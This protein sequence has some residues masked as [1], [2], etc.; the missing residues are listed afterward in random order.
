M[1]EVIG[2]EPTRLRSKNPPLYLIS[3]TSMMKKLTEGSFAHSQVHINFGNQRFL[4]A[5]VD[6][7]NGRVDRTRTCIKPGI[8]NRWA[9]NCPTTRWKGTSEINW[10]SHKLESIKRNRFKLNDCSPAV[11]CGLRS[12][13]RSDRNR[14]RIRWFGITC[15]TVTLLTYINGALIRPRTE[16]PGVQNQN[17]TRLNYEGL[18]D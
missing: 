15:V 6:L 7:S 11:T 17:F 2:F 5:C 13:G 1:V 16:F 10:S 8:Q 4:L 12:N 3:F 14:T 18:K 9:A